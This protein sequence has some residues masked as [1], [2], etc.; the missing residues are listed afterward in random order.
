MSCCSEN[1][2]EL[3]IR[4][5]KIDCEAPDFNLPA[6]DPLTDDETIVSL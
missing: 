1:E 4:E 5:V 3:F 2:N 6:Y